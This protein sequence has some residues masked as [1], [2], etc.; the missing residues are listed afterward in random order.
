MDQ[1][2]AG[3]RRALALDRASISAR[4][5]LAS[6]LLD[7][8]AIEEAA[9]VAARMAAEAADRPEVLWLQGRL[10]Y[11]RG[12]AAGARDA[13]ERLLC[14]PSLN[15]GQR[16]EASLVLGLALGD[17]GDSKDAFAM[18]SRGKRIQRELHATQ[19][20][21]R[22][23]EVA[24][25]RRLGTWLETVPAN[26]GL[27]FPESPDAAGAHVFLLGFPRSGTTLLE[28]VLAAHPRVAT[29]EEAPTL[30]TAYQAFLSGPDAC[31]TLM[32]V[33]SEEAAAWADHYWKGV[34]ER[35]IDVA[36][37]TFVDKQPAGT[38]N[39]PII[40][41][42]FPHAKILFAIRDPRDVVLSCFRQAFQMNAMTYAFTDLEETAACYDACMR[43]AEAAR[44]R[45]KLGWADVRHETLVE[46]FDG[47]LGRILDFLGLE[48]SAG[49]ADFAQAAG[50]RTIRTPSA[51]QVRAGL[52][53]RG[54]GR[55]RDY[56]D[57]LAPVLPILAPWVERFDYAA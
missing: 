16:A 53:R 23:S 27:S 7:T 1:A 40:A 8:G 24:K 45:L 3:F 57:A 56:R 49:M 2:E 4:F 52:N 32:N 35:G 34:R 46:D 48:P 22:E 30:A 14:V 36:G 17:L 9:A 12:D 21:G 18:A 43:L 54:L 15:P 20:S 47:E 25:L 5:G 38:L 41:R 6:L 39:L 29:L 28:Q 33:G 19:A 13:L 55:W 26:W 10:A 31:A 37:R 11:G 44:A 51:P 50:A 42:L